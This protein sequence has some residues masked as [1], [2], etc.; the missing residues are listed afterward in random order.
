MPFK[1]LK[2]IQVRPDQ[3]LREVMSQFSETAVYTQGSG[4]GVVVQ[5]CGR[6]VGIVT[7]GDIRR[8]LVSGISIDSPV[9][10]VMNC[11]FV[12]ARPGTSPHQVL[13]LFNK[14]ISTIPIV[15]E[16]GALVDLL[17]F[18]SFNASSRG[19]KRIIRARAPV[20]ISFSGGG[21]DMTDFF[22]RSTGYVL[23]VAIN[24]Y[25]Y[26]SILVREDGKIRLRSHDY[27]C[28]VE[29]STLDGLK[30]GDSLDMIKAC[31]KIMEPPFGFD[32]ETYS[33]VSPGTGLGGSSAMCAAVIGAMNRFRNENHLD[34]Y[35]LADLSYQAERVELGVAGGWQDQYAA[36]FGG[37]NLIEFR[38][39]D[40]IVFPLKIPDEILLELHYNLL[41]F[42]LG[43][44]RDSGDIVSDQMDQ[45]RDDTC[46][47]D[48]YQQ[49]SRL[50]LQMKD[51][52]LKGHLGRFGSM[53]HR[54]WELKK[55]FSKKISS[56]RIDGL[57][58]RARTAGAVGG[59]VLGAGADG[60]LM[61]YCAPGDQRRVIDELAEHGARLEYFD[62]LGHGLQTWTSGVC[63]APESDVR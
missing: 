63:E 1:Y 5:D 16:E 42:R 30:Y 26:A 41:L 49:L 36:V 62:F 27:Q 19:A 17:Q 2:N 15:S 46:T 47:F 6:C 59:K 14:R 32:L 61:L 9:K 4:F 56:D 55:S 25:C 18:S 23:S 40:I 33:E 10:E 39:N 31:V 8:R 50:T 24:K 34:N 29:A 12:F 51:A 28:S 37:F 54:G 13:R 43:G 11:E 35:A 48:R 45:L 22:R 21:T 52:L 7:D 3:T 20:R 53:L 60:Y 44:T 38:D 58:N 57:Y